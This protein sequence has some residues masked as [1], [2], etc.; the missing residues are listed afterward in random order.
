MSLTT[1]YAN[2]G[3]QF[4]IHVTGRFDFSRVQEFRKSYDGM[5]DSVRQVV[6]DFRKTE[7]ID[8]SG[9]GMLLNMR[10]SLGVDGRS[11]YL[12]NCSASVRKV[13]SISRFDKLF[14]ID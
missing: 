4:I 14:V 1:E 3:K 13:L 5:K 9:L 6:I 7:Y 10:K 2:E 12:I 8:S 11:Y